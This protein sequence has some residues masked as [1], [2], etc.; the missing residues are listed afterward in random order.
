MQIVD[1]PND[2]EGE[3]ESLEESDNGALHGDT[4]HDVTV[5]KLG[6]VV[7]AGMN[8]VSLDYRFLSDEFQE[9]VGTRTTTRSSPRSILRAARPPGAPPAA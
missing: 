6:V 5:L 4:D 1:T 2:G 3:G 7:P 8:C 9:F